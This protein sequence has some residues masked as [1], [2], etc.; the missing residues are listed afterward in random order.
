MWAKNWINNWTKFKWHQHD[1]RTGCLWLLKMYGATLILCDTLETE[2]VNKVSHKILLFFETIYY[3]FWKKRSTDGR[4]KALKYI[5]F[6]INFTV[7]S[8]KISTV[9]ILKSNVACVFGCMCV[10][11]G[12]LYHVFF[13]LPFSLYFWYAFINI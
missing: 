8:V 6:L 3:C 1:Y 5:L 2:K 4:D 7:K 12:K 10:K 9:Y 11:N 13:E